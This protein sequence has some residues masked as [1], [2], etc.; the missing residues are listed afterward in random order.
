MQVVHANPDYDLQLL[1]MFADGVESLER[2]L[3]Q[4]L[5]GTHPRAASIGAIVE[6]PDYHGRLLDYVRTWRRDRASVRPM[7]RS[8][9]AANPALQPMERTFGTLTEA[10]RYFC[11]LPRRP[12]A[13]ARH[14][15]GVRSFP[16]HLGAD[17][18]AE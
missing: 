7:L 3:E 18:A 4:M 1:E 2:Q 17:A 12:L 13:A 11:R 9:V 6:E 8:N 14:L 10:M 5:A 15:L 16:Y